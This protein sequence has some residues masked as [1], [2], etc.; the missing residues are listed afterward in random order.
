MRFFRVPKFLRWN[1]RN[2]IWQGRKSEVYLTFDDGP[3]PLVTPWVL[4]LLEKH[5]VHATFFC[6]GV[7]VDS[8][9]ELFQRISDAGHAV[10]HR[11]GP[12]LALVAPR[13]CGDRPQPPGQLTGAS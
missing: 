1:Y 9:L 11:L 13:V 12:D 2:G 3:H 5:R 4:D 7:N 6:I 8:N 10:G